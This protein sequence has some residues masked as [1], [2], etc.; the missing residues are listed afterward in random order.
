MESLH[1]YSFPPLISAFFMGSLGTV[2][3][4]SR[5]RELLY[6]VFA[7]FCFSLAIFSALT[8]MLTISDDEI[9]IFHY[10]RIAPIFAILSLSFANYYAF[11]LTGRIDKSVKLFG[12]KVT[13]GTAFN[14]LVSFNAILLGTLFISKLVIADIQISGS[15]HIRVSYTPLLY[16]LAFIVLM[17]TL[18]NSSFLII[19]YRKSKDK[20]FREF[21]ILNI[22]GFLLIF[23]PAI[24]LNILLPLL[25]IQKPLITFLALPVSTIM[26]YIAIVRYQFAQVDELNVSLEKKVEERTR[27]LRHAQARL[28]QTEKMASLG[29]LV[30]GVAHEINNPLS[31]VKST[32]QTNK[33]ALVKLEEVISVM[34]DLAHTERIN[35]IINVLVNG[36]NILTD[37]TSR[38]ISIVKK[39][40]SFARLDEA[41]FQKV[42]I[43][44]GLDDTLALIQNDIKESVTITK[45]YGPVPKIYC[46]PGQLN[47]VFLNMII[48]ANQAIRKEGNILVKTYVKDGKVYIVFQDSGEGI[49]KEN[50]KKIFDPGFTTKGVGVGTGLGL[51]I[52]QQIVQDHGGDI[53]VQSEPGQGTT[54]QIILPVDGKR[55]FNK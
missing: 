18:R 30:A 23:M 19:G 28:A 39:L 37:G 13:L 25:G 53:R 52:C 12:R 20:A 17:G 42:D 40:K 22:L 6:R 51:A 29:Q 33:G 9:V 11:I 41:E 8:F 43:H 2:A 54:F 15:G 47:Q 50:L 16:V 10:I 31:A 7:L 21:L 36:N 26:F 4:L 49:K 46:N 48:N 38:I 34:P 14:I 27:E 35:T 45:Q 3:L 24:L 1:L 32:I 44:S 55:G 5:K